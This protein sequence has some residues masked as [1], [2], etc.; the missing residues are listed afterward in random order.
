M[1]IKESALTE[2]CRVLCCQ[3]FIVS[4]LDIDVS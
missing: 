4:D 2:L 1:R 3:S